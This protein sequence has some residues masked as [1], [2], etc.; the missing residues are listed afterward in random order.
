MA[1]LDHHLIAIYK[2]LSAATDQITVDGLKHELEQIQFELGKCYEQPNTK[3]F[4]QNK[5]F[6]K[7]GDNYSQVSGPTLY[8]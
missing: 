3:V 4:F 8:P 2:Q 6:N 7:E 1:F 5:I